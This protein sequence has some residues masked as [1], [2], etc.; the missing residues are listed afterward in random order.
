MLKKSIL[1]LFIVTVA[2]VALVACG[3]K[4]V[5]ALQ[6]G[7]IRV[8]GWGGD[9]TINGN[10]F[11]GLTITPDVVFNDVGDYISYEI[12]LSSPDGTKYQI[13]RVS[14][15]NNNSYVKSSYTYS[16]AM[17]ADDKTIVA[18]LEYVNLVPFGEEI[19]LRDI[20][21]SIDVEEEKPVEPVDPDDKPDDG[22]D[23]GDG[24][25]DG[26]ADGQESDDK[27]TDEQGD[28]KNSSG[29]DIIVPN[30]GSNGNK[31]FGGK[32]QSGDSNL[33]PYLIVGFCSLFA[34]VLVVL[35]KRHRMW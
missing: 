30:T 8:A 7:A 35:P 18:K 9:I 17:N 28:E 19:G 1:K 10:R 15:D 25:D 20:H 26:K 23:D 16:D 14:D 27:K 34:I 13:T 29:S 21:V 2:T 3:A 12:P 5:L 6:Y 31:Y 32:T 22:G 4:I 11:D 24:S 33:M